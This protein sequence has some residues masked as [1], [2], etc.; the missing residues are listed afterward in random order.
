MKDKAG[1]KEQLKP[2]ES[3]RKSKRLYENLYRAVRLMCDNVPDLIW[4][5]DMGKRFIFVNKA[6]CENL[7]NAKDTDEPI[8]KTDMYFAD[9]ERR[10]H[11]DDQEWHTFG[12]ICADSDSVVMKSRKAERFDE[13]GNVK[14]NYL[15]LDVYKAPMW[16]E[17]GEMIG[18]VGCGREV[19]RERKIEEELRKS[20][21]RYRAIVEDQTELICRFLP[22]GTVTFVNEAYCRYF[23]KKQEDLIGHSF[24]PLIPDEDRDMVHQQI[25]SL[26]PKTP[27]ITYEHR[28][29]LPGGKIHWMSWRDHAIFDDKDKIIEFQSVG[30]NITERKEMEE[31]LKEAKNGLEQQVKERTAELSLKNEQRMRE[32]EELR[33][34]EEE[35]HKTFASL[36]VAHE[37]LKLAQLQVIQAAKMESVGIL[38]AGVAHEVKNPLATI[39]MGVEYLSNRFLSIDK[40]SK[41]VLQDMEDAV[42]R[43]D[44]IVRDLLEFS[45]INEFD[46]EESQLNDIILKSINLVKHELEKKSIKLEENLSRNLSTLSF[47]RDGICQVFVNI[48]LN[49]IHAS[50]D[51]GILKVRTLEK[52]ITTKDHFE[53][54]GRNEHF[55][56]GEKVVVAEVEDMGKGIQEEHIMKIFD[57]FFTT[58]PTGEGTGLGLTVSRRIIE[59]HGGKI[60]IM[61]RKEGG[62][63]TTI[64]FKIQRKV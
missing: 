17:H 61:N 54:Y 5:K 63:R 30:R 27:V 36:Q 16:D 51:G 3:L 55:K 12:E 21:K 8:G 39:Q 4:A 57:P 25:S 15:H 45:S 52:K 7:L 40:S 24:M 49:A 32:I 28:V 46:F 10:S 56:I 9:R 59:S 31:T 23:G 64:V 29:I 19:T 35:L 11:P 60:D 13:F 47:S 20:E 50:P 6:I 48:F 2:E 18:T 62:V 34:T 26:C 53:D 42:Y 1:T 41:V 58:K 37:E 14:G 43:A 38:A 33:R 22:D 44:S